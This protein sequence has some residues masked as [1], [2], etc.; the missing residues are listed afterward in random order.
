MEFKQKTLFEKRSFVLKKNGI[1]CHSKD[2]SGDSEY[3]VSY[4]DITQNIRNQYDKS[5]RLFYIT[6]SFAVFSVIGIAYEMITGANLRPLGFWIIMTVIIGAFYQITKK[7]YKI[8]MLNN[9]TGLF[10]FKNKP[11]EN[12]VN[13]FIEQIYEHKRQYLRDQYFYI[14]PQKDNAAELKRLNWLLNE[15]AITEQELQEISKK[16]DI[17]DRL[18]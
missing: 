15:N 5:A 7:R 12:A 6:L 4:E 17:S 11:N 16:F 13:A 2:A 3:F 1:Q 18:N 8:I 14:D 9:G 10:M